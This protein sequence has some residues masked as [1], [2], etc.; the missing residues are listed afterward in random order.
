LAP[1]RQHVAYAAFSESVLGI[2]SA[3]SWRRWETYAMLRT[4]YGQL[5]G[6]M[7]HE[8]ALFEPGQFVYWVGAQVATPRWIEKQREYGLSSSGTSNIER[9]CRSASHCESFRWS[10]VQ[11]WLRSLN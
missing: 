1:P 10:A 2:V 6:E 4:G 11:L 3:G 7:P 5:L 8:R 9:S